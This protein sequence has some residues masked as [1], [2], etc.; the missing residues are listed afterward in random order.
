MP[1]RKAELQV[2]LAVLARLSAAAAVAGSPVRLEVD[3]R[4]EGMGELLC[5]AAALLTQEMLLPEVLT[6][7]CI[8]AAR[9]SERGASA[10][11]PVAEG[12]GSTQLGPEG[13]SV[14]PPIVVLGPI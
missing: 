12:T 5:A 2:N 4:A 1:W 11:A 9:D 3:L 7:V 6:Q 13:T 8:V 10:R 14:C